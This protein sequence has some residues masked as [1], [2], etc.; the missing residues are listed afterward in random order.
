MMMFC[1]CFSFVFLGI[2]YQPAEDIEEV[3]DIVLPYHQD[4]EKLQNFNED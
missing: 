3:P 2:S 1:I 4:G